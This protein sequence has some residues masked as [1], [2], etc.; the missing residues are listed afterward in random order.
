MDNLSFTLVVPVVAPEGGDYQIA[1][2]LGNL[3]VGDAAWAMFDPSG[4]LPRDPANLSIDVAGKAKMDLPAL[5]DAESTGATAPD[6]EPLSLD[7]RDL[8]IK[9]AG[10]A[11]TGT[12]SFTFDNSMLAMGGPPMPIG[13]ADL[14]LEGG[15]RLIDGLIAVGLMTQE[16]A[17]GARMMMAMFGVPGGEDVLTS[18]IEAREGG[19]IFVNGQQIQ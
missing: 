17:M 11:L 12:G 9:V 6:P 15:N 14:R 18:K 7:L 2:N 8:A 5:M 16:D 13:A 10:A 4:A 19:S 3:V 1:M